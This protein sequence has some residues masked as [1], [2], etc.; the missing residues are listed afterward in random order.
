MCSTPVVRIMQLPYLNPVLELAL[1]SIPVIKDVLLIKLEDIQ[2]FMVL[3]GT[4]LNI[5]KQVNKY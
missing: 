4:I 3:L 1:Q 2:Y 5:C